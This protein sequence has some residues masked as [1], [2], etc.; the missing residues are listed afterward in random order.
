MNLAPLHRLLLALASGIVL[1]LSF[2]TFELSY[3]AWVGIALLM[4]AALGARPGIAALC[5]FL[6]G[7]AFTHLPDLDRYGHTPVRRCRSVNLRGIS[8]A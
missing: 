7:L 4:L 2:P 1:G 8:C 5:G 3:L 6:H